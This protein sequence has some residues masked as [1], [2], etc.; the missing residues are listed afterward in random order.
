MDGDRYS[1]Q[2]ML[3]SVGLD[4]QRR[5]ADARVLIVGAGGLGCPA[6]LYLAAAG[7]GTLGLVD[8]DEVAIHNL[9]RQILYRTE[10][11]GTS[12]VDAARAALL[13]LNP[14]IRVR[15]HPVR[16]SALNARP[17]I[18]DYDLVLDGTDRFESRY[19][20]HDECFRQDKPYIY[21]A[22]QQLEGQLSVFARGEGPCY[23][24]LYPEPPRLSLLPSGQNSGSCGELGVIG[25]LPGTIGTLMATE[26]I[27]LVLGCGSSLA[28]RL[29]LHDAWDM[30]FQEIRIPRRAGCALCS[31]VEEN[32]RKKTSALPWAD[33]AQLLATDAQPFATDVQLVDVRELAESATL[34]V[35]G[36]FRIPVAELFSRAPA[37]LDS[38]KPIVVFCKR[39]ARGQRAAF[40]LTALG[41]KDVRVL[42]GGAKRLLN[43]GA[44]A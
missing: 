4:G 28:G 22:I 30:S 20:L 43:E 35:P 13:S 17:L 9:H 18:E 32:P 27:K 40:L 29:L 39:E 41:F 1:R 31:G 5:L 34:A 15:R 10:D 19:A 36:A 3:T 26:A 2:R 42:D 11:V 38:A 14:E 44:R 37:E 23:R 7:I 33:S 8:D 16:A 6:A 21:G 25:T 12:K 24:C